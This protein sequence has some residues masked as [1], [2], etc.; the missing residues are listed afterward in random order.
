MMRK[1]V[2]RVL[3]DK[4]DKS[5]TVSVERLV[6]HPVYGKYIRRTSTIIAHDEDNGCRQ[7]DTVAISECR[8]LSRHKSWRVV[9]IVVRAASDEAQT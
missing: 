2:G 6:R 4:M 8:P 3:S 5:V 1:V 7:G 9:E